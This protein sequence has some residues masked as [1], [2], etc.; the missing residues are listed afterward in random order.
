M[1]NLQ[2]VLKDLNQIKA[3]HKKDFMSSKNIFGLYEYV[4]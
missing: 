1:A 3:Y 4:V 2:S